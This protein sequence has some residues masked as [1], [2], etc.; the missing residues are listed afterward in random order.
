MDLA[1]VT[2]ATLPEPDPDAVPLARALDGAGLRWG[3]FAWDAP[4]IDWSAAR[5][6]LFRS[7][8]NYPLHRQA[9]LA[10]AQATAQV[11]D[12]WNPPAVVRWSAHKSYLLDLQARDIPIAPTVLVPRGAGMPL[13][14]ICRAQGWDDVVI[15]P[16]VSAGSLRTRRFPAAERTAGEAHLR[17]LAAAGDVLIQ[18]YLPA[19]EDYGERALVWI[20]GQLTHAVRKTPRFE[21]DAESVSPAAVDISDAEAALAERALASIDSPLLYGRVDVAPGPTGAPVLM[22]LE[23]IE[24]SLFFRQGPQALARLLAGIRRR[25]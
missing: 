11:T 7:T 9:F 12:L 20:D 22:E 10:W 2:C 1:L 14:E 15:K 16:A 6:T 3:I 19:V 18:Q 8:W 5:L 4:D 25:L 23:L 21:G 24:P 13:A 17:A